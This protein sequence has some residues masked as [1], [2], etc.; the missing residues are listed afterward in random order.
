MLNQLFLCGSNDWFK[1]HE[2]TESRIELKKSE[3]DAI[4]KYYGEIEKQIT[5]TPDCLFG[6]GYNHCI[7]MGFR[8]M[9]LFKHL[10]KDIKALNVEL[11]PTIHPKIDSLKTFVETFLA[12]FE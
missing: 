12:H 9:D 10:D 3:S 4:L 6:G 1:K 7:D 5:T 8:A 2:Q 11:V